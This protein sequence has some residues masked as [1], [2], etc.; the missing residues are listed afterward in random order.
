LFPSNF[1]TQ[2]KVGGSSVRQALFKSLALVFLVQIVA[3]VS[4]FVCYSLQDS[5]RLKN[6]NLATFVDIACSV[7]MTS[8]VPI[9][10]FTRCQ[11]YN[12][13]KL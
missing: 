12:F 6:N 1:P 11:F 2:K 9:L 5:Q 4:I 13:T 3:Y 10:Y 8:E 7:A